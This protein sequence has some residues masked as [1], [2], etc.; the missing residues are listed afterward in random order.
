MVTRSYRL[1]RE[2]SHALSSRP[3]DDPTTPLNPDQQ[4]MMAAFFRELRA[5][6]FPPSERWLRGALPGG[7]SQ[8]YVRSVLASL[9]EKGY[10]RKVEGQSKRAWLPVL[11]CATCKG[12]GRVATDSVLNPTFTSKRP[13]NIELMKNVWYYLI[14]YEIE[15]GVPP[16]DRQIAAKFGT[17]Y[18]GEILTKLMDIG[19]VVAISKIQKSRTKRA[20]GVI[21]CP[22]CVMKQQPWEPS[23]P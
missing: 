22:D 21:P 4:A 5:N 11:K 3:P 23:P 8:T 16:S 15:N 12:S 17:R 18:A 9:A 19:L 10:L 14:N 6:R 7:R 2:V 13:S 20:V 1:I